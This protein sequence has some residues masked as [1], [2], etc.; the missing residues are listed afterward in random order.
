MQC[1]RYWRKLLKH[2]MP[3]VDD[4]ELRRVFMDMDEDK[5]RA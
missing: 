2:R 5:V 4:E 3:E 1:F